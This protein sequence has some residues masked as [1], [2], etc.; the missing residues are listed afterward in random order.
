MRVAKELTHK[1]RNVADR[2]VANASSL[3]SLAE[4]TPIGETIRSKLYTKQLTLPCPP[5][6]P[7]YVRVMT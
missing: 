4:S 3:A 5:R 2:A 6:Y 7:C 1:L